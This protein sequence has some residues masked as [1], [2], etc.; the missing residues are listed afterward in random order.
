MDLKIGMSKHAG[1]RHFSSGLLLLLQHLLLSALLTVGYP[2]E[3]APPLSGEE[4]GEFP[5]HSFAGQDL[6]GLPHGR[7][8]GALAACPHPTSSAGL[9]LTAGL[10]HQQQGGISLTGGLIRNRSAWILHP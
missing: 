8:V 6:G 3:S 1:M 4:G 7:L 10:V 5:G 9:V 2:S